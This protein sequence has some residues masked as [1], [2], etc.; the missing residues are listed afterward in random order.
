MSNEVEK[1]KS[2]RGGLRL[3]SHKEGCRLIQ[4]IGR[5]LLNREL[6]SRLNHFVKKNNGSYT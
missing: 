1:S 3:L 5:F 4:L 6:F 2:N